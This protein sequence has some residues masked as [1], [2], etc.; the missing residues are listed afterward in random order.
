MRSIF[1]R[2]SRPVTCRKILSSSLSRDALGPTRSKNF[3]MYEA[4]AREP[5]RL[6]LFAEPCPRVV[7]RRLRGHVLLRSRSHRPLTRRRNG[8][9]PARLDV[10]QRRQRGH[11]GP[12]R[13]RRRADPATAQRKPGGIPGVGARRGPDAADPPLVLD[14]DL[15]IAAPPTQTPKLVSAGVASRLRAGLAG[16]CCGSSSEEPPANP[17]DAYFARVLFYAPDPM[18]TGEAPVTPPPDPPLRSRRSISASSVQNSP[19]VARAFRRCNAS[20][21]RPRR[22][23]SWSGCHRG[24]RRRAST[25]WVLCVRAS[26]RSCRGLVDGAGALRAAAARHQRSAPGAAAQLRGLSHQDRC[27]CVGP[28]RHARVRGPLAAV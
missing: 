12:S 20:C 19:T 6:R 22:A 23:T 9:H 24:L 16:R 25:Y 4:P 17:A 8:G 15:P 28:L 10:E 2:G 18:L 1:G 21:P 27:D 7:A 11:G 5:S 3:S 13:R 26:S 14:I